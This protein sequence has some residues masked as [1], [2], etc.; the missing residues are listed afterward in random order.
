MAELDYAFLADLAQIEGG[1]LSALGASYTHA[2]VRGAS[3]MWVT[4]IAGRVR[5]S[6]DEGPVQ[7]DIRIVSPSRVFEMRQSDELVAGPEARPYEGTVGILFASTVGFPII[8][9]GLYEVFISLEG[10]QVRRLAFD[11]S[12]VE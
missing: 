2:Q 12:V 4:S 9:A 10:E 7:L 11:M 8:E 5:A 1:K 6:I 3:R